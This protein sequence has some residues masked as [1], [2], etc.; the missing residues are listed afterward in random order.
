MR[1]IGPDGARLIVPFSSEEVRPISGFDTAEFVRATGD[2]YNFVSRPDLIALKGDYSTLEFKTGALSKGN[3]RISVIS[4]SV[5]INGIV[6]DALT[7][8]DADMFF[9]DIFD[10]AS[11]AFGL[12]RPQSDPQKY[13]L[14]NVVVEFDTALEKAISPFQ[15]ILAIVSAA[16]KEHA[17]VKS[18]AGLL[19]LAFNCDPQEIPPGT[20]RTDFIIERRTNSPY[21]ANRY[22]CAAPFPTRT[23]IA[24]LEEI[25]R[26]LISDIQNPAIH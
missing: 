7:T 17:R 14:S 16:I 10:W 20:V 19:R 3:K 26:A 9:E 21:K 1:V 23:L 15:K 6:V 13:Y 5:L 8:E 24:K 2:R 11:G 4:L 18:D 12:R 22:F 25:E